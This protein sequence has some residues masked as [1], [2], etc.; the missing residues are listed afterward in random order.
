MTIAQFIAILRARWIMALALLAV[1]VVATVG[2]SLVWPKSYKA[3]ASIV[4]DSKPDPVSGPSMLSSTYMATQVDILQSPRVA[5]RVVRNLKLI[6]NPEIRAQ[7]LEATGGKGSVEEWLGQ[8]FSRSLDV[9]PSRESNVINVTYKSP[10]PRFAAGLAN[11]F[12]TAYMDTTLEMRTNPAKQYT[13]FFDGRLNEARSALEAS[14]AKLTKFQRDNGLLATDERIDVENQR[15]NELNSQNVALS[16]LVTESGS[17]QSQAQGGSSEMMQDVLLNP[18]IGS[19]KSEISRNE[20]NLQAMNSRLGDSHPQ[21][22]EARAN[23]AELRK[24]MEAETRKVTG[25]VG[26]SNTI[27]KQRYVQI[28][29]DLEA[30][31]AKVLRLKSL[32]DEAQVLQRD[33]E[34]NQR[35]YDTVQARLTQTSLES[36]ANQTNAYPLTVAAAPLEPASPR[37]LFNSLLAVF[38]GTLLGVSAALGLEMLDRRVRSPRDVKALLELPVLGI[39]PTPNAK[40]QIMRNRAA[41]LMQQRVIGLPAPSLGKSS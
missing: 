24:R 10:D 33:V 17:R 20:A 15:L 38:G 35:A 40:R 11:A 5:Q 39:L 41:L 21:V 7:W 25:G 32:R 23:L 16:A 19:L 28:Q 8:T 27:N 6:D 34:S 4:I 3:E 14:Q 1:V 36:Q 26:V 9:K 37:V 13:S 30:Q 2:A 12:V 29:A 18:I 22:I 31:R